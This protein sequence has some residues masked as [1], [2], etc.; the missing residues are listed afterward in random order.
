MEKGSCQNG[1]RKSA[2]QKMAKVNTSRKYGGRKQIIQICER[3]RNMQNKE[4]KWFTLFKKNNYEKEISKGKKPDHAKIME[5]KQ[6]TQKNTYV[7]I[8]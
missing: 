2:M 6:I 7:Y 5:R 1:E 8:Q 3:K 4:R